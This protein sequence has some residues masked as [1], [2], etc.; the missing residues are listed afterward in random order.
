MMFQREFEETREK[1]D[2][3]TPVSIPKLSH[4]RRTG[5]VI[6]LARQIGE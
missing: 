4:K 6:K 2:V 1:F 3:A 5:D